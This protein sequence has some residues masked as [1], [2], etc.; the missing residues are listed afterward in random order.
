MN[1]KDDFMKYKM[2]IFDI[3]GTLWEAAEQTMIAANIIAD[4][5]PEIPK[6]TIDDINKVM[7]LG[8]KDIAKILMPDIE[9]NEALKYVDMQIGKA[10]ELV[11]ENGAHIY[12]NVQKTIKKLYSYFKLGIITNNVDNY[13]LLFLEKSE[14]KEYFIDYIGTSSYG[15][16]KAKAMNIMMDRN[17]VKTACYIGD[18]KK[19]MDAAMEANI[20]F[21]HARY[22][23]ERDLLCNNHIDEISE[24]ENLL[25]N[26]EFE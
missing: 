8:K 11:N 20:D 25:L 13:A 7:G 21:I 17:N 18:I 3:D 10:I 9:E 5:Y 24:L 6:V 19:D 1:E 4:K 12:E 14:L 2:L 26:D 15:I 22:G 16:N 23:F